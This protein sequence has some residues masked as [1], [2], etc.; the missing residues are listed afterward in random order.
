MKGRYSLRALRAV[1]LFSA[2]L[3][4]FSATA[5]YLFD[6]MKE[7]AFHKAYVNMMADEK[8]LPAWLREITGKGDYVAT[9]ET[10]ATINGANY[11]LFHACEEQ[12]C[13]GH[14]LEVMFS[15]AAAQAFGLLVDGT[16]PSRWFGHPDSQQQAALR[17]AIQ[18]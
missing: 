12:D 16:R 10:E 6:V 7:P 13:Y 4:G 17:K 14:E 9:P 18:D 1:I 2:C 5:A 15:P 8:G 11:R 3:W